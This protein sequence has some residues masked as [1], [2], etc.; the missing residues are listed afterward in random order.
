MLT[1]GGTPITANP[2][3]AFVVGGQTAA[4]GGAP[5]TVGGTTISI[6]AGGTAAVVNG[7]TTPLSAPTGVAVAGTTLTPGGPT[8]TGAGGTMFALPPSATGVIVVNGVTRPLPAPIATEALAVGSQT[9]VAGGSGATV[10]GMYV[11]VLPG[12][13]AAVVGTQT[14]LLAAST[15]TVNLGGVV[16]TEVGAT[17][18][19]GSATAT[20][21]A[22]TTGPSIAVGDGSK[23]GAKSW[24]SLGAV[25]VMIAMH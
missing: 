16:F 24:W 14:Q 19:P 2:T 15:G 5:I 23:V 1:V 25:V 6:A 7:G 13:S 8:V 18:G 20:A 9:L 4:P 3:S 11:S 22:A 12:G 10:S 21:T 17:G